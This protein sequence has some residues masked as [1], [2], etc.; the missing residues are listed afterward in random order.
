M[1]IA[2]V[3]L[4]FAGKA[5]LRLNTSPSVPRGL[6]WLSQQQPVRGDY[7]AV[8][9]P[10]APIFE[11]AKERG[12]FGHGRCAGGYSELIKVFAAGP[13]DRVRIDGAACASLTVA[14]RVRHPEAPTPQVARCLDCP[15]SSPRSAANPSS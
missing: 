14:G 6:Y 8:C 10:R 13:G 9:P 12:Y 7:V 4:L 5:G 3:M 1:A 15:C 2:L 11:L